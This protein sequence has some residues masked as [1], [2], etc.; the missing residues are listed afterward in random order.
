MFCFWTY[1]M[2]IHFLKYF[3]GNNSEEKR[4]EF[5]VTSPSNIHFE[6]AGPT[7]VVGTIIDKTG[8]ILLTNDDGGANYNFALRKHLPPGDYILSVK[9]CCFGRGPFSLIVNK[10]SLQKN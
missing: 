1:I 10:D 8:K 2:V 4:F 5:T 9:H 7:D 6:S 3:I